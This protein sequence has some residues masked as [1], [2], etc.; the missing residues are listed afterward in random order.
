MNL[1]KID[2]AENTYLKGIKMSKS[3]FEKSE[4]CVNMAQ[5]YF[6]IKNEKKFNEWSEKTL[7]YAKK[8][9]QYVKYIEYFKSEWNKKE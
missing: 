1:D 9:S 6:K 4:M 7:K 3:D 2:K 5:A 8:G